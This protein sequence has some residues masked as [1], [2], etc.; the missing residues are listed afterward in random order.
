M[1]AILQLVLKS[2][3]ITEEFEVSPFLGDMLRSIAA[4]G[5]EL[6][7]KVQGIMNAGKVMCCHRKVFESTSCSCNYIT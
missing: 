5:S 1:S 4:S 6:G 3:C 7:K 2:L